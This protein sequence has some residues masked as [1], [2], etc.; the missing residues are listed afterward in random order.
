MP[1]V[2]YVGLFRVNYTNEYLSGPYLCGYATLCRTSP[3]LTAYV[4]SGVDLLS[5]LVAVTSYGDY[6]D[7]YARRL[8]CFWKGSPL[9]RTV[10]IM[11]ETQPHCSPRNSIYNQSHTNCGRSGH[12]IFDPRSFQP[13]LFFSLPIHRLNYLSICVDKVDRRAT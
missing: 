2:T 3:W 6:L 4:E 8:A 9:V 11:E 10:A 5:I 12:L 1:N 7:I 13:Y